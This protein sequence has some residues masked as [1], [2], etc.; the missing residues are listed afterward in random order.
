MV[1]TVS[2]FIL[3]D[4]R[5]YGEGLADALDRQPRI[6]VIGGETETAAA[7]E[8]IRAHQPD[9]VAVDVSVAGGIPAIRVIRQAAPEAKVVAFRV[10][11]SASEIVEYAEAGIAGYVTDNGSLEQLVEAITRVSNGEIVCPDNLA[12]T[13]FRRVGAI[14]AERSDEL[15]SDPRLTS[16]ERE[17]LNLVEEGLSNREIGERLCIAL[18]TVKNHL[19]SIF[20]KLN[21]HRRSEAAALVRSDPLLRSKA[22]VAT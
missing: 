5:L 13:L 7:V 21:V 22:H 11:E 19:H 3:S 10:P 15:H 8:T 9:I 2:V 4:L 1:R 16:R 6:N 12:A 20:E 18:P 14:A 17:V